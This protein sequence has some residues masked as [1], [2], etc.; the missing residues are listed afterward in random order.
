MVAP[1]DMNSESPEPGGRDPAPGELRLVQQFINSV[2][3]EGGIE[4]LD[5]PAALSGWLQA[6]GLTPS[7]LRL[8]RADLERAREFRELLR[9]LALA[10]NNLPISADSLARLNKELTTMPLVGTLDGGSTKLRPVGAGL[11]RALGQLVAIVVTATLSGHWHRLKGCA[12]DVCHWVFYDQSRSGTGTW[13]TMAICGSRT[14]AN[15]YYRRRHQK[16]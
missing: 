12:R 3:L 4:E 2:D 11:D 9:H 16:R 10:N 14:K 1:P 7:R 6:H 8:T 15:A 13:C 5:S